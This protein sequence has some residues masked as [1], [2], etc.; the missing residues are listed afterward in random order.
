MLFQAMLGH[1]QINEHKSTVE[2]IRLKHLLLTLP[3]PE[4]QF[5]CENQITQVKVFYS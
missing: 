1:S 4:F 2:T 3:E 5:Q